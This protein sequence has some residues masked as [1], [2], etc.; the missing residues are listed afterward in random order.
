MASLPENFTLEFRQKILRT[1]EG[2]ATSGVTFVQSGGGA[3]YNLGIFPNKDRWVLTDSS[4]QSYLVSAY[5]PDGFE[6]GRWYAVKAEVI[7]ERI[8]VFIDGARKS[9]AE[10]YPVDAGSGKAALRVRGA[11]TLFDDVKVTDH[12]TGEVILSESFDVEP[13]GWTSDNPEAW[14]WLMDE[15]N[16]VYSGSVLLGREA[17]TSRAI[18]K[19]MNDNFD[20]MAAAGAHTARAMLHW[21]DIQ[22]EGP[23]SYYWDSTDALA[24]A[25][26]DRGIELVA[27]LVY[28]PNWAVSP[29]H[30]GEFDSYSYPPEKNEDYA[31]FVAET[32]NRYKPGGELAREMGWPSDQ[33]VKHYEIGHE[34]NVGK[35]YK[36][37]DQLFF[38]GWQGTLQ[39]YVD[40][41]KAG[42]DAVKD[43]CPDCL[44][45]NGAVADA[46]PPA[47]ATSRVDPNGWRQYLWQ[48]VEDLYEEIQARHPGDPG[49]IDQ[50]FDILNIHTYQWF[51]LTAQGQLPDMYRQYSFPDPLWYRDRLANV[52]EVTTRYGDDDR[53]VWLTETTYAS[54]DNGDAYAGHLG[55]AGQ[56]EALN[57][58]YREASQFPQIEK[59]FWWYAYDTNYK[60]GLVREDFSVKPSYEAFSRLTGKS[61]R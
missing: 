30:R 10:G 38:S 42:R 21:N 56:A 19:N 23:E 57:M 22:P 32:V 49:V 61:P 47:Y 44:V 5:E 46:V 13:E 39:Q 31:R 45:L 41:L 14:D 12:R 36:S 53:R 11:H 54:S 35:I 58:I 18:S 26:H 33:G 25:A 50:Y 6:L 4:I 16:G 24:I 3:Q 27:G 17:L 52:V 43:V 2:T 48:G 34:F 59:V 9:P 51:M 1:S 60:V 37:N 40:L 55:E 28:A 29:E 15:G 7:E 8:H 20:K